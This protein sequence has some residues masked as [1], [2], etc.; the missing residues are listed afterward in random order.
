MRTVSRG[1]ERM[2]QL[3]QRYRRATIHWSTHHQV[4]QDETEKNLAMERIDYKM[5][6]DMVP[7]SWITDCLK[8]DAFSGEVIKFYSN[9]HGKLESRTD[10][11][12]KKLNRGENH[13]KDLHGRCTITI[14]ICNCDDGS[15]P[16]TSETHRRIQT[17]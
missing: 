11:K 2:L 14:S 7:Q 16:Q 8:M 3:D 12:S 5:S 4:E 1:T 13:E 10:S 6:N 15:E 17:S 9:Y